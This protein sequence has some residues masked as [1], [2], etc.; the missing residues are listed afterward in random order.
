[1]MTS[2]VKKTRRA[3]SE[4]VLE[5]SQNLA[6]LTKLIPQFCIMISNYSSVNTKA[7]MRK[8][9]R[10]ENIKQKCNSGKIKH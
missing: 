6:S 2:Q 7:N 3:N 4:R 8:E 5:K 9:E 10:H 1:M